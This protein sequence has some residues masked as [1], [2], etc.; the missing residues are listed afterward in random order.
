MRR[1]L[2]LLLSILL[3]ALSL[4]PSLAAWERSALFVA[5][6]GDDA[7]PG[8]QGAPLATLGEAISRLRG[9]KGK[10]PATVWLRGGTYRLTETIEMTY[11]DRDNIAFRAWPGETPILAGDAPVGG[12]TETVRDGQTLWTAAYVSKQPRA[13]FGPDGERPSARWPKEGTL[14]AAAP[15]SKTTDKFLRQRSF[16]VSAGD[17]PASLD[18]AVVRLV[19]WWKDELSGVKKYDAK[20]GRI[21]LNRS[22]SMS[23]FEGDSYWLEN[24]LGAPFSPG[25]WAY[26]AKES[27][28]YYAPLPGETIGNTLL[29]V[30]ALERLLTAEGV[31]GLSFEGIT[32]ARTGWSIPRR[33]AEADFPQAAYDADTAVLVYN[34]ENVSF[35]DC[36]FR[37]M[38][39]GALRLD[40]NVQNAVVDGCAFRNIGA[41]AVQIHGRNLS[42]DP[43]TTKGIALTD[44]H[45]DGYGA[46]FLNAVAVLIVHAREIEIARNEIH[47]GTYTAI[48]AG[49]VWGSGYNVTDKISVHNNLI[50]DVGRGMLSDMGGVYLLGVQKNTV[51]RDN[52]ISGVTARDYGGWGIYLDEGASG[53]LVEN[54]LVYGCSA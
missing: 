36:T 42:D 32:F 31:S 13:L 15:A 11:R 17:L 1:L 4:C 24:V 23:V 38:G 50:Y 39:A 52:V 29:T 6:D 10:Q 28:L 43:K 20:K 9:D 18:G 47:G 35:T 26:D 27:A 49:W 40:Y 8:T 54:N 5:T 14:R 37:D 53:V 16:N 7:N 25:E 19:H 45:V 33:D 2:C 48:S 22:T 44:N 51:V 34:A 12:W 3:C 30:G 21:T 46:H 41:H